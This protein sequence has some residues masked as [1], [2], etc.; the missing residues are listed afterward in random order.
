MLKTMIIHLKIILCF[1]CMRLMKKNIKIKAK[2]KLQ[3]HLSEIWKDNCRLKNN[4]EIA[5]LLAKAQA[6]KL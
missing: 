1:H 4:L 3:W 2:F 5:M 6:L